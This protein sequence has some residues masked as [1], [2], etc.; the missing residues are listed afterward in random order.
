DVKPKNILVTELGY[1][2]ITDLGLAKPLDEDLS[3]TDSGTGIG[4]PMYMAPE[5][6]I[7]GKRADAR[8]D[9]YALGGVLYEFL[10][11][12]P[13]FRGETARE[14]LGAK[15][16][17]QFTPA[18]RLNPG[19]PDRLDLVL[20]RMLAADLRY[21]YPSCAELIADLRRIGLA[22]EHLGFNVLRVGG[23]LPGVPGP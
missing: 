22:R 20:D 11:G 3:L 7:N 13:P 8:A 14:M 16:R 23:T 4:T 9:I 18:R 12:R 10:T 6:V 5:Q 1:V 19:L 17:G 2:K 15:E 21:R